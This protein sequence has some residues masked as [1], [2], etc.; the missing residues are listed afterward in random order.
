MQVYRDLRVLT[1]RPDA[2]EEA[3]APHR[4]FGYLDGAEACSAAHWATDARIA[5][6]EA[7]AAGQLPI[8]VGGTGLYLRTLLDGIAPV[9]DV[10]PAVRAAVRALL[11]SDARRQLEQVDPAAAGRLHPND[12]IR[13]TRA[14][15]VA[16]SSGRPL[17]EWQADRHGGIGH[18]VDLRAVV[19]LP[20]RDR[21]R[22]RIDT[23]SA[24]MLDTGAVEE[25][26]TLAARDLASDVPVLQAIGVRPLAALAAG[27]LDRAAALEALAAQTRQYAKRQYT[28]FRHQPPATWARVEDYD[29]AT[30]EKETFLLF[31]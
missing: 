11:L 23:R 22:T 12:A 20:D 19:L 10:D 31:A 4:L 14:L 9:P 26:A 25:A 16:L 8:L 18:V 27:R 7:H 6:G 28:W 1:A 17:A 13:T 30:I 5:I 29:G 24:A 15:E 3:R 21:L 2:A